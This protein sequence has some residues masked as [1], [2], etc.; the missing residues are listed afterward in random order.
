MSLDIVETGSFSS[1]DAAPQPKD[2]IHIVSWNIACGSRLAEIIE[3][4]RRSN[5][6]LIC[7]Q[8]TD[9][10]ARRTEGRNIAA[11]IANALRMNYAF[12][13]EFQELA[14]GSSG[15]PAYHGQATLSPFP[16]MDCRI[17]RFRNQSRFW[18]PYW[19]VPKVAKL[20]RRLGGRMVLLTNITIGDKQIAVYNL[21]LESRSD[22]TRR[23]QLSEVLQAAN[24]N[25]RNVPI[26]LAG[27]FNFDLNG[28]AASA[29]ADMRF[30]NPFEH[31][32]QR[33][34]PS[35]HIGRKGAIDWILIKGQLRSVAA[36]VHSSV[37]ASDHYP[38]SLTLRL[39]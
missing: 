29:V 23:A 13:I 37:L 26:V 19:W 27:D 7:L 22:S 36:R 2:L 31:E 8:E 6:D 3:F 12:G 24:L 11:E 35:N 32:Q 10:H 25:D 18:H 9:C 16:L 15:S 1:E 28:A 20:Q 34:T 33:T 38:L 39:S 14:E 4:L 30:H 5:A 21:H 17:L